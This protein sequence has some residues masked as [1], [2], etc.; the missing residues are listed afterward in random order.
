M[1]ML[2]FS[3][4]DRSIYDQPTVT[5]RAAAAILMMSW[6]RLRKRW[7]TLSKHI[8]WVENRKGRRLLLVDVLRC[9]YPEASE[10]TIHVLAMD[11]SMQKHE[12][13]SATAKE[14]HRKR[15]S[16]NV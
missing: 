2:K 16:G 6:P 3:E 11:Y 4:D 13:L 8:R 10:H 1:K 15:R 12:R 14:V 9:A 7:D 5:M